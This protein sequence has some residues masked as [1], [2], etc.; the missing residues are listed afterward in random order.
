MTIHT[1]RDGGVVVADRATQCRG[2]VPGKQRGHHDSGRCQI[3]SQL[4]VGGVGADIARSVGGGDRY[5]IGV[6]R[7]TRVDRVI[8][9]G[10]GAITV[11]NGRE[12]GLSVYIDCDR[13]ARLINST[14]EGRSLIVGDQGVDR[15]RRIGR[16][17][18]E[19]VCRA[20]RTRAT[21]GG[22]H[23]DIVGAVGQPGV[24]RIVGQ[25]PGAVAIV[26]GREIG[27]ATHVH[28]DRGRGGAHRA[29]EGRTGVRR[30]EAVD[31]DHGH[32][33]IDHQFVVGGVIGHITQAVGRRD[34]H[35]IGAIREY[36]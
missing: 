13:C 14:A 21:G 22:P 24:N 26:G 1:D 35:F 36:G 8:D 18:D 6:G 16:I 31:G 15:H 27:L 30:G 25:G 19:F 12:A 9:K 34:H 3:D 23:G 32:G 17:D 33:A 29:G 28:Q 11:V 20:V 4:V 2:V 5:I 7:E 10:P